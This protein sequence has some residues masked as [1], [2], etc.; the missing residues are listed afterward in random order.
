MTV[1]INWTTI[2]EIWLKFL[3]QNIC[4]DF[5]PIDY[6][7]DPKKSYL[8]RNQIFVLFCMPK[9]NKTKTNKNE[10]DSDKKRIAV[11]IHALKVKFRAKQSY[12]NFI[13]ESSKRTTNEQGKTSKLKYK[14]AHNLQSVLMETVW[15]DGVW[16]FV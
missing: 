8:N 5:Y 3:H 14:R 7:F 9:A 16:Y 4:L 13:A 15:I 12:S 11:W 1:S 10:F 6:H 2:Q